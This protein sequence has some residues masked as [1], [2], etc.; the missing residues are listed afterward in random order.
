MKIENYKRSDN[1]QDDSNDDDGIGTQRRSQERK[2]VLRFNLNGIL[3]RV[4]LNGQ[5][6]DRV[7]DRV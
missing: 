5:G 3:P 7:V 6:R 2:S 1:A 4:K